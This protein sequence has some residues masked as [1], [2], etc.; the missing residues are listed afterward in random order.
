MILENEAAI[1]RLRVRIAKRPYFSVH[2]AFKAI[3]R[4]DDGFITLEEFQSILERYGVYATSRDALNLM[5]RYDKSNR[6]K[7][8]YSDFVQEIVPKSP[9]RA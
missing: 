5:R 6:G 2:D 4:D 1:E 8:S 9:T 7:V 3:D